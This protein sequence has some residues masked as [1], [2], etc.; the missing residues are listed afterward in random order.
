MAGFVKNIGNGLSTLGYDFVSTGA[1]TKLK[2]LIQTV[3][4]CAVKAAIGA[5]FAVAVGAN[6]AG[7]AVAAVGYVLAKRAIICTDNLIDKVNPGK[8]INSF[9]KKVTGSYANLVDSQG[10]DILFRIALGGIAFPIASYAGVGKISACIAAVSLNRRFISEIS[11]D[12]MSS[13]LIK[14]T[15]SGS[16]LSGTVAY[17]ICSKVTAVAALQI[18]LSA[19]LVA[20]MPVTLAF[21]VTMAATTVIGA[22]LAN[23][24]ANSTGSDTT[25]GRVAT[26]VQNFFAIHC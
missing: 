9:Y 10:A 18:G 16:I 17:V 8:L 11:R 5:T 14:N 13:Y 6:P 23:R 24:V 26:M 20:S 2:P 7:C 25:K 1:D 4:G 22:V 3:K 21:G 19:S 15:V 12:L